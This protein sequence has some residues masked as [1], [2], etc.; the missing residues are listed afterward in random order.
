MS[1]DH[2]Y[3][4]DLVELR[5]APRVPILWLLL[6]WAAGLRWSVSVAPALLAA[7]LVPNIGWAYIFTAII[8]RFVLIGGLGTIASWGWLYFSWPEHPRL[9]CWVAAIG[10]VG[11]WMRPATA[12]AVVPLLVSLCMCA[13]IIEQAW[14]MRRAQR[15]HSRAA[16]AV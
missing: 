8:G 5:E 12:I 2:Q 13:A 7:P 10:F 9:L 6:P 16:P 3:I 11:L 14:A 1:H 4:R 15:E